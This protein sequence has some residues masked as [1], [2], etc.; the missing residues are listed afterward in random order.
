MRRRKVLS[1]PQRLRLSP[2]PNDLLRFLHKVRFDSL[3]NCW[4]WTANRDDDGYGRFWI[5]GK[6]RWASRVS[7]AIF[8]RTIPDGREIDH[9][10]LNESCV[11]PKHLRSKTKS[12]NSA[13]AN[14]R[15]K[16]NKDE[17]PF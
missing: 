16:F 14:R 12:W 9:K 11:N 15:R 3:T 6:N 13:D 17:P 10:C 2:T 8:V 1:H 4:S 7:Y 5:K